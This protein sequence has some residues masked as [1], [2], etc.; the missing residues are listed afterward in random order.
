MLIAGEKRLALS[1]SF[2]S[3]FIR[4][5]ARFAWKL[6]DRMSLLPPGD[7]RR[8]RRVKADEPVD[9][10]GGGT[11]GSASRPNGVELAYEVPT[12]THREAHSLHRCAEGLTERGRRIFDRR[13]RRRG[14]CSRG[15]RLSCSGLSFSEFK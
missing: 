9:V 12:G 8:S 1:S 7:P 15:R 4:I 11:A 3:L 10:P 6:I 13:N 5:A 2:A 14:I